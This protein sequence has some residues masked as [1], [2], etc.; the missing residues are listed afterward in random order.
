[1]NR[2]RQ[3]DDLGFSKDGGPKVDERRGQIQLNTRRNPPEEG[4]L[5]AGRPIVD[6]SSYEPAY[7]QIANVLSSEIGSGS[8]TPG[9]QLPTE[10]Q[11]C[12]AFRVS[13]MTVRRAIGILIDRGLV[14]TTPGKGTF[15]RPLDL[16]EA[17]FR[18]QEL[19]GARSPDERTEVRLLEASIIPAGNRVARTLGLTRGER[20]VLLRRLLLR[21]STPLMYQREHV[22]YDP[23]RPLVEAQLRI[24]SLEGLL[25]SA[26]SRGLPLADLV[27]RPINTGAGMAKLLD[28]TVGSPAFF[29][30]HLFYD[31]DGSPVSWG[32]FVCPAAH[33]RL[34]SRVGA[35]H[36]GERRG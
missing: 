8:Y 12:A 13:P 29:L 27:I 5:G 26:G 20:I 23:R 24:S 15:V 11:L 25:Q 4:T 6:R 7:M 1:V 22:L 33:F 28:V 3:R 35:G 19:A 17:V 16:G 31:F 10:T 21:R 2:P 32:W 36:P 14:S 18:L 9:S 34:T 30:E